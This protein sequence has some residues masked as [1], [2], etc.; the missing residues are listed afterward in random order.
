MTTCMN[1]CT[2]CLNKRDIIIDDKQIGGFCILDPFFEGVTSK[3]SQPLKFNNEQNI[4]GKTLDKAFLTSN[5][6]RKFKH[7]P[8][9]K[10]RNDV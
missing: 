7:K 2:K 9:K 4:H 3:Y 1:S 10:G 6:C 8:L 5:S